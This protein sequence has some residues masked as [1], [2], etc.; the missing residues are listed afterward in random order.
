MMVLTCA[1]QGRG[2]ARQSIGETVWTEPL[3]ARQ[4]RQLEGAWN[5]L[6]GASPC[7]RGLEPKLTLK[8]KGFLT[9][10]ECY[11]GPARIV[12]IVPKRSNGVHIAPYCVLCSVFCSGSCSES[13]ILVLFCFVLFLRKFAIKHVLFGSCFGFWLLPDSMFLT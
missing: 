10:I 7:S 11:P 13:A 12:C 1:G 4:G 9:R 8:R 5:R 3:F 2:K 6:N